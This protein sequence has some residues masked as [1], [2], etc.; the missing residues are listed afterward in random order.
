V[1]LAETARGDPRAP[2]AID[3]AWFDRGALLVAPEL[4]GCRLV[5]DT[6]RGRICGVLT[7]VEAYLGPEDLAAHS[8]R[9]RTARTATMFGP[10]GHL[11]VYL[12]YGLHLCIN[13]VCGPGDKPEAVL[14]RGATIIEGADLARQARGRV[15]DERLARGPGNLASAFWV[16]RE[17][18]GLDLVDGPMHLQPGERPAGIR[19]TARIG[20]ESAGSWAAEPLRFVADAGA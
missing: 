13:V 4:L 19:R 18:D 3:R 1:T 10:P 7:E 14:L 20:V 11:Y 5:H 2:T 12:V 16:Q 8:S 17:F 15:A 9:P 6:P